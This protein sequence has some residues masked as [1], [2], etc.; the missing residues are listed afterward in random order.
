[1]AHMRLTKPGETPRVRLA[2]PAGMNLANVWVQGSRLI[3]IKLNAGWTILPDPANRLL[4][5]Y[6]AFM[7]KD[8]QD[9]DQT[10]QQPTKVKRQRIP[11]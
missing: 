1:M 4:P 6:E 5:E 2:P 11:R 8:D 10:P 3:E 9:T 7:A